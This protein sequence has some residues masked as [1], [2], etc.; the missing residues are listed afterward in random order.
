MSWLWGS[1]AAKAEPSTDIGGASDQSSSS[2]DGSHQDSGFDNRPVFALDQIKNAGI[3][4]QMQMS[5]YL[6]IDPS[7]F[8][9]SAPQYIM[10]DGGTTGKGKFEFALGHIGW[11]VGVGFFIGC[12]RGFIPELF[13]PD[14]RMLRGKPWLTRVTNATVK[15]GSG[16][17]QPAG[18]AVCMFSL[19]EIALRKLRPDDDF[20]SIA[21]GAITGALYR[22]AHGPRA[23]AVGAGVGLLLATLWVFGN[24]DSRQRMKEMVQ[25]NPI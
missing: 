24:A 11:A 9:Q 13:N 8:K 15:Y 19:V 16:Y 2:F 4:F 3:P 25:W 17:A 21:A 22:S 23:I 18:A 7:V 6:Q 1:S 20:N 12:A 10:P 14:T 5:P